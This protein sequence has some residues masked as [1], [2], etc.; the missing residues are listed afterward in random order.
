MFWNFVEKLLV[1][2]GIRGEDFGVEC[3]YK[4]GRYFYEIWIG[5]WC[6]YYGDVYFCVVCDKV[7]ISCDSWE[8]LGMSYFL[9]WGFFKRFLSYLNV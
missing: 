6:F 3:W 9:K 7:R 8:K 1:F 5:V 4:F 2:E